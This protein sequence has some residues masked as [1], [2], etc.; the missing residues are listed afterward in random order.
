MNRAGLILA[1]F[2]ANC[3]KNGWIDPHRLKI[4]LAKADRKL[5]MWKVW[6]KRSI[7]SLLGLF[8]VLII[9][10]SVAANSP[11]PP[12][13]SWLKFDSPAQLQSVQIG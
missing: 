3:H 10:N 6:L 7:I 4:L 5:M 13:L 8:L 2:T 1:K 12:S 9:A 11:R